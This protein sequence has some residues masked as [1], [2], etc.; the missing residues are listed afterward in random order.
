MLT[1]CN[2]W[3]YNLNALR[4]ILMN[5]PITRLYQRDYFSGFNSLLTF[6][7]SF[8]PCNLSSLFR[9]LCSTIS[10][11]EKK[12]SRLGWCAS[13]SIYLHSRLIGELGSR[14][15]KRPSDVFSYLT[16]ENKEG[17]KEVRV[18]AGSRKICDKDRCQKSFEQVRLGNCLKNF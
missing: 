16:G 13:R 1:D 3:L 12:P 11:T 6:I 4:D 17:Q 9:V 18:Q 14:I 15:S 8:P 5:F 10:K 2:L 7:F